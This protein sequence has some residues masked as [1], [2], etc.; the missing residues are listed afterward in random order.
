MTKDALVICPKCGSDACYSLPINETKNS[1]NCMGCGFHTNDLMLEGEFDPFEYELT[2]PELYKDIKY[3]DGEKRIWY[4]MTF[5]IHDKGTVFING[6]SKDDWKWSVIKVRKLS[7]KEQ[8]EAI[9]KGAEYKSDPSTMKH[10]GTD[11]ISACD[12]LGL[13][14]N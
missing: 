6:T 11:F 5:N 7:K 12:Y 2:M 1:Y 14:D 10:F 3:V 9:N 4:P 13:F 8:K